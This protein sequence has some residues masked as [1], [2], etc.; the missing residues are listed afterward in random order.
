MQPIDLLKPILYKQQNK[1][2]GGI[3]IKSIESDSLLSHKLPLPQGEG[4]GEGIE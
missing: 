3:E 4:W 2:D 1:G